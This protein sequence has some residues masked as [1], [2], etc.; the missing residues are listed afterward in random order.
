MF[1]LGNE[2]K[3]LGISS[4]IKEIAEIIFGAAPAQAADKVAAT[5]ES[6]AL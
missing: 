2:F 1:P 4:L 6:K 5:K 3:R